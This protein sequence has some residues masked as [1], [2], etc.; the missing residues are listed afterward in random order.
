[1][2]KETVLKTRY[3]QKHDIEDNWTKAGNAENPFIPL[4]GEI[5]VYDSIDSIGNVVATNVRYKMGDGV[6]NINEL[7][8]SDPNSIIQ[9]LISINADNGKIP[10][11]DDEG[12]IALPSQSTD[13]ITEEYD[14]AVSGTTVHQYVESKFEN[15]EIAIGEKV[16]KIEGKTLSTNDFTTEEKNKLNSVPTD[17]AKLNSTITELNYMSGV[18]SNVQDQLN[19][20]SQVQIIIWEAD[21]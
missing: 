20:K 21:D 5:I 6:H 17:I 9:S 3:I 12:D 18:T 1:M 4:Q 8:F 2:S 15:I 10:L 7:P 19:A 16:D 11:R 13:F 14:V